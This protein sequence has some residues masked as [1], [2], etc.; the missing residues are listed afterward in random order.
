[1]IQ[2]TLVI[3]L[4]FLSFF[5]AAFVSR[6]VFERLPHLEDEVAYLFQARVFAH[7]DVV[8]DVP[9]PSL[10]FW[11]PFVVTDNDHRFSK[12]SPGWSMLLSLGINMGQAWI[13]N[14]F[15]GMLTVALT[16][17]IGKE[18]FNPNVGFIAAVLVTFSPMALLL[19]ATLMGHSTALTA[20]LFFILAY[21]KIEQ[22]Q[23]ALRWGL[24][25]G[26]ALGLLVINRQLTAIGAALP[27][28]LWSVVNL[29]NT[30]KQPRNLVP[31]V[32][33]SAVT[34]L[35][36]VAIPLYNHAASGDYSK[37][38]YLEVWSYDRVGFGEGYG[39]NGH[40]II[41]GVAHARYDLS[42]TAADLFGWV[43]GDVTDDVQ[44]HLQVSSDYFPLFGFGFLLIPFGLLVGFKRWW[45]RVWVFIGLIWLL[46]PLMS[47]AHFLVSDEA[48]IWRWL[49]I[50]VGLML[51]P[52]IS[53][54]I[55]PQDHQTRW[56]WLF[57]GIAVSLIGAHMAYWVGSQRYSTRYYFE[58]LPALALI[59]ALALE[60]VYRQLKPYKF[61]AII[62]VMLFVGQVAF[63]YYHYSVPRIES[64]YQFNGVTQEKIDAVA[65]RREDNR[66]IL[67]I[68]TSEPE[69]SFTWR[70]Y[71]SLTA[72][73]DPYF[74]NDI[75]VARDYNGSSREQIIG[76]FP[77]RQ[78]I[79]MTINYTEAWFSD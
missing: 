79:D 39:R 11:Q 9:Q 48:Q 30:L 64:L 17:R 50:G 18:I 14:A 6:T 52:L 65:A 70:G 27:F 33:L 29:P 35:I 38:L 21:W 68:V 12:Y 71:G 8:A 77:D 4:A 76:L 40:T 74:E 63:S 31:Y 19:N 54:A 42:L 55:R 41:K 62:S 23:N 43:Q 7:G 44:K 10:A 60:W 53:F 45:M 57:L 13:I 58:A 34:L 59:T 32:A 26:L 28:I 69:S 78:V 56:T 72:V 1:M 2:K 5:L 46:P 67:V 22:K 20:L 15:C 49:L 25:G 75:I 3:T 51:L 61:A 16:Y 47:N 73:T 37:N 66:P 24:I 36:S